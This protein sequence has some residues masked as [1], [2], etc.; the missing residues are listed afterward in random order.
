MEPSN[1]SVL[2]PPTSA[3]APVTRGDASNTGSNGSTLREQWPSDLG[4]EKHNVSRSP[5]NPAPNMSVGRSRTGYNNNVSLQEQGQG[6]GQRNDGRGYYNRKHP[7]RETGRSVNRQNGQHNIPQTQGQMEVSMEQQAVPQR[8]IGQQMHLP[9]NR[10]DAQ[11]NGTQKKYTKGPRYTN[12]PQSQQQ[13]QQQQVVSA[14]D[15]NNTTRGIRRDRDRDRDRS[16]SNRNGNNMQQTVNQHQGHQMAVSG[17]T[18]VYHNDIGSNQ[19]VQYKNKHRHQRRDRHSPVNG[20]NNEPCQ[21]HKPEEVKQ[22]DIGA[23]CPQE[24]RL[25][26]N[27]YQHEDK[28]QDKHQGD[29]I[30]QPPI[31]DSWVNRI[32]RSNFDSVATVVPKPAPTLSIGNRL[33]SNSSLASLQTNYP[34]SPDMSESS[35]EQESLS[36]PSPPVPNNISINIIDMNTHIVKDIGQHINLPSVYTLWCHDIY[37]KDWSIKSYQKLFVMKTVSDFW[38]VFNNFNKLGMKYMHF[39]L[40]KNNIMPTWESVDNRYGGVCSFKSDIDKAIVVFEDLNVRMMC[41][42]LNADKEDINGIS[43]S[44]K[45]NWAMIKVWNRDSNKDLTRTMYPD[46]LAKYVEHSLKYKANEPEY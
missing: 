10:T 16:A 36:D 17:I 27:Q 21:Q 5:Q 29:N 12:M 19:H 37:N 31:V 30:S 7:T 13:Q 42:T 40:M 6:Q 44:P 33:N 35:E 9:Q 26:K 20:I 23:L 46:I 32:K 39:F 28:H 2:M 14:P 38:S 41:S 15:A 43:I 11:P 18:P 22:R 34:S 4:R 24:D 25:D 1:K 45:N 8:D 3:P